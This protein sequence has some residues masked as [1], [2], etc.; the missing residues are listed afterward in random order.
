M[1]RPDITTSE[2]ARCLELLESAAGPIVAADLA[3]RLRLAG[4]RE[5][6]RRHVRRIVNRLRDNG[7]KIVANRKDGYFITE[8]PKV[9]RDY[10]EGCQIG[11]KKVL[12]VTHK[13]KR[14]L[15]DSN[16]QGLLFTQRI[17]CGVASCGAG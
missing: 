2:A 10:L 14:M 3:Y 13:R 15:A 17:R 7:S 16:G 11:A 1:I 5:S 6:Q 12:G 8:D 9:L 4:S